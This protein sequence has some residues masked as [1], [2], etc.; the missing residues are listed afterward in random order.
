[1]GHLTRPAVLGAL[2]AVLAAA[3][4]ACTHHEAATT[5]RAPA[6]AAVPG[7][8]YYETPGSIPRPT[9]VEMRWRHAD[10]EL[11]RIELPVRVHPDV[12]DVPRVEDPIEILYMFPRPSGA[13][14]RPLVL[15]LPILGNGTLLMAEFASAFVRQGYVAAIVPR[16][17]LDFDP[18]RSVAQA[19]QEFRVLIM[20]ARQALDWLGAQP[21]VDAGRTAV[22]GISAG[23]ILGLDLMAA[24]PRLDAGVFVFAG[25]PMA[26]VIMD[27]SEGRFA[28]RRAPIRAAYGWT[29]AQ[30]REAL[31]ARI[32]TDPVLLAPRVPRDKVLLFL[33]TDDT[34]VPTRNQ[35]ALWE[36]LGRPE[37]HELRGGHYVGV[38]LYLPYLMTKARDFLGRRLG[39][40]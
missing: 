1:M 35:W 40:P 34:S 15:M 16:K 25:G 2:L 28:D 20:R 4:C 32:R 18:R 37:A 11:W 8:A 5:P 24:D 31:R 29:D 38:G 39:T 26:D 30:L 14:P 21:R 23:G 13:Q 9:K 12:A 7:P 22:F 3:P 19:E 17:E 10:S 33:A 6:G 36:A 27:T